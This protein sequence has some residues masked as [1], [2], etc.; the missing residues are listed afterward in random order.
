MVLE[1]QLRA[2]QVKL[3]LGRLECAGD[4]HAAI[5]LAPQ[6]RPELGQARQ[7]EIDLAGEFLLQAAF[8]AD[9]V[10]AE[11][12]LQGIEVPL[13]A[14]AIGLGLDHRRLTAQFA[15]EVQVGIEA[16]H[17]VFHLARA[18]Q[19]PGQCARQLRDPVRRVDR[20]QVQRGVP[21][22]A[23][24][25][26]QVQVPFS[27]A[28][29][30][31]ELNLLQVDFRQVARERAG[32]G[33]G[34]G[35]TIR[36]R[37]E[38]PEVL[39]VGV[40][41]FAGERAKRYLRFVD[42]RIEPVPREIQ[43]VDLRL[44]AQALAPIQLSG[45]LEA[46]LV[47]GGQVQRGDLRALGVDLALQRQGDGPL[48]G[49]QRGFAEQRVAVLQVACPREFKLIELQGVRQIGTGLEAIGGDPH[50]GRQVF[51]QRLQFAGQLPVEVTAAVGF[52]VQG[53]EQVAVDFQ[54]QRQRLR[55]RQ[56]GHLAGGAEGPVAGGLQQAGQ[57]QAQVIALQ[58][59][60][61]DLQTGRRPVRRQ[62]QALEFFAAVEQQAADLDLPQFEGQR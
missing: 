17:F 35:R 47:V 34:A 54:R 3:A 55:R 43:P 28:L 59:H 15:L 48:L 26:L 58:R 5:E 18:A 61:V 52:Q 19:R 40:R 24:G 25:K 21:G 37:G 53:L 11:A 49:G 29:P 7:L 10:V 6:L 12:N 4:I 16:E 44:G 27:L 9:A 30:G 45:E 41:D 60:R 46:L 13:L 39:A 36:R 57:V 14:T 33:E 31:L 56:Q 23:V 62:L 42:E 22:N 32:Q 2:L 38:M 51:H 50:L 1:S 8:A 20:R